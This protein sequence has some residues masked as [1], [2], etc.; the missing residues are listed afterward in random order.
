MVLG[1]GVGADEDGLFTGIALIYGDEGAAER[2]VQVLKE[3]L[4]TWDSKKQ[5]PWSEIYSESE[6]WHEGR[7]LVSTLRS[8]SNWPWTTTLLIIDSLL[9]Y[10]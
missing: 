7:T 6:V 4:A 5:L 9:L 10:R 1:T 8:E 2:N 3:R